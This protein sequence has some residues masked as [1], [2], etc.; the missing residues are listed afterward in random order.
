MLSC[1]VC[2][3][4]H[5]V[6]EEDNSELSIMLYSVFK[7]CEFQLNSNPANANRSKFADSQCCY[8]N[9]EFIMTFTTQN[10]F[11][12]VRKV[13]SLVAKSLTPSKVKPQYKRYTQNLGYK[14][15]EDAFKWA[16]SEVADAIKKIKWTVVGKI[17]LDADKLKALTDKSKPASDKKLGGKKP[18]DKRE[19]GRV[20]DMLDCSDAASVMLTDKYLR[21]QKIDSL[22]TSSG[23]KPLIGN[24]K[25]DSFKAKMNDKSKIEKFVDQKLMK[26]KHPKK[27]DQLKGVL[28]ALAAKSGYFRSQDFATLKDTKAEIV[29]QIQKCF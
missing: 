9:G 11:S 26:L 17:K 3:L 6:Q 4:Y 23:L 16:A 10:S 5:G 29:K 2:G 22:V 8:H 15:N 25:I 14:F 18:A 13:I 21:N 24:Q 19:N 1:N 12:S 27:P 7:N 28:Y 20:V